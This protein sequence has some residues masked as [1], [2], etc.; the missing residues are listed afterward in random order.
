LKTDFYVKK[1]LFFLFLIFGKSLFAQLNLVPKPQQTIV[2]EKRISLAK[3]KVIPS[4]AV[5]LR[6]ETAFLQIQL[7]QLAASL[8][9]TS[10]LIN[11]QTIERIALDLFMSDTLLPL[12]W[13]SIRM[14]NN[15]VYIS[16]TEKSG[17]F[18]GIQSLL[19]SIQAPLGARLI[20]P[21]FQ[22]SGDFPQ[23]SWRGMHLDVSRHFFPVDFILRY[24]DLL[25]MHKMNV[26]HWHLTD[27]QGWRIEIKK[28]PRLTEVGAFRNG[29]MIGHY[30]ENRFDSLRYGGFYTQAEIREIVQYAAQRHIT[31][32]PEIEMPGHAMAALAAYPQYSCAGGPFEVAKKWG[33]FDDVFCPKEETFSFLQG[34][35]D[36]VCDLFPG[37][38][39]HI[40]GD[41][42][43]KTRWEQCNACKK[44]MADEKL[45]DGHELQSYFIQR[46]EK[47]LN[48]KGKQIIGWDEI[49]EGGLAPN[50]AVMSWRGTEGGIAAANLKHPVVMTPGTHCYFDHYQADPRQENVAI[51]GYT[52]LE[53]VLSFDPV[54]EALK[55]KP[56][57][58][59][60]LGA[61]GNVWT[62]YMYTTQDVERMAL[63]RMSALAEVL[64]CGAQKTDYADFLKRL[65]SLRFVW[66]RN[67]INYSRSFLRPELL[68]EKLQNKA[69]FRV[70]S[71]SPC[72]YSWNTST[73]V[74]RAGGYV[75][76]NEISNFKISEKKTE[77]FIPFPDSLN[78]NLVLQVW[79]KDGQDIYSLTRYKVA[80]HKALAK[81]IRL[82]PEPSEHYPGNGAYTLC[83]GIEAVLPR[84][85]REWLGWSGKD[86]E[87]ILDLDT[88]QP[89]ERIEINSLHDPNNWIYH[90]KEITIALSDDGKTW[91]PWK[92]KQSDKSNPRSFVYQTDTPENCRFIKINLKHAGIIPAG[93]PGEGKSAWLFLDEI[94]L[95]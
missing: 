45:K 19:Q 54:P 90:P 63:P 58:R 26:F 41:E 21:E 11:V 81:Q 22:V 85:N 12:G 25:A 8:A 32:V 14:A 77:Q 93:A 55:G 2:S 50:A 59:F 84:I 15:A 82:I 94:L 38:Y 61:Q 36:E 70:K 42:C 83:D 76:N 47:Y 92:P 72:M 67:N 16:A 86:V 35:L 78:G 29:S 39:F 27:D 75:P 37:K 4:D 9:P 52:T 3:A 65:S 33:V 1:R 43:P 30:N 62:E 13:Y 46:I 68:P 28:H 64:W 53:K 60:I 91:R 95:Y 88:K 80:A 74:N 73:S 34:I 48:S 24:I 31:I 20:V 18:Y 6:F 40:G 69:G 44:R 7:Q 49:L 56:E 57:A 89:F 5:E 10:D 87:L 79:P 71:Q 23:F 17:I 66:E 51:G